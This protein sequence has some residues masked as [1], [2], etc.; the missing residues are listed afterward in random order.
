[1]TFP[2]NLSTAMYIAALLTVKAGEQYDAR[3]HALR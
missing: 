3:E 2:A 1:M